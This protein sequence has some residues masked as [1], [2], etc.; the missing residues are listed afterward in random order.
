MWH[1]D[2]HLA[3]LTAPSDTPPNSYITWTKPTQHFDIFVCCVD[4]KNI[5]P[6]SC[7][8]CAFPQLT[9]EWEKFH[10]KYMRRDKWSS[11][12]VCIV[13][14]VMHI[15]DPDICI[16]ITSGTGRTKQ[17]LFLDQFNQN[18]NIYVFGTIINGQVIK[19]LISLSKYIYT[20][21]FIV[22]YS[23]TLEQW[24]LWLELKAEPCA[25]K[26]DASFSLFSYNDQIHFFIRQADSESI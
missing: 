5:R 8:L 6:S 1:C 24:W 23:V 9:C 22:Q 20:E 16:K 12:H 19:N 18:W 10:F 11:K 21:S 25:Y 2:W 15:V 13:L 14:Y 3:E 17:R 4:T 7:I 26:D